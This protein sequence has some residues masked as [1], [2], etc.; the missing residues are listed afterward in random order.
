MELGEEERG[1]G[2]SETNDCTAVMRSERTRATTIAVGGVVK[3]GMRGEE[4]RKVDRRVRDS[5]QSAGCWPPTSD[6]RKWSRNPRQRYLISS[7]PYTQRVMKTVE[8]TKRPVF[9]RER[10]RDVRLLVGV[11]EE[12]ESGE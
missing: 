2:L 11:V 9:E 7:C 12:D 8:G 5:F 6:R 1:E 3:E 10:E 4:G